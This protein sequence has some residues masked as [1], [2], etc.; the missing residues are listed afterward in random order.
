M[1]QSKKLVKESNII[2]RLQQL[3]TKY[4]I[5]QDYSLTKSESNS[6]LLSGSTTTTKDR[7]NDYLDL[8]SKHNIEI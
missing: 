4:S 6:S 8:V 5:S 1:K 2:Q 7:N 3:M